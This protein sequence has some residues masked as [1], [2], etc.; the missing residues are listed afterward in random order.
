MARLPLDATSTGYR[1]LA[2]GGVP[3]TSAFAQIRHHLASTLGPEYGH[4]LAEPVDGTGGVDWYS[5]LLGHPTRLVDFQGDERD[6]HARRLSDLVAGLH[7]HAVGLKH[8]KQDYQRHLG[9][10]LE[11]ALQI[12]DEQHVW[13]VGGQPVLTFWGYTAELGEPTKSPIYALLPREVMPAAVP[14]ASEIADARPAA[15]QALSQIEPAQSTTSVRFESP[16]MLALWLLLAAQVIAIGIL[17]L[18]ACSISLPFLPTLDFCRQ[19]LMDAESQT[20][21]LEADRDRLRAEIDRKQRSCLAGDPLGPELDAKGLA[22]CW[23]S[24]AGGLRITSTKDGKEVNRGATAEYCFNEE[25][26]S[27]TVAF[28]G[29]D[30][31][32]CAGDMMIFRSDQELRFEYESL[33]CS[34][35]GPLPGGVWV[36]RSSEDG[37]TL[38][39]G[40][41]ILANG[42][43]EP[44]AGRIIGAQFHRAEAKDK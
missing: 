40:T 16:R 5:D 29:A 18:G 27:G 3:V 12:P 32:S 19:A 22:G 14:A 36:C 1:R 20:A 28:R 9:Q 17:L 41:D 25:G 13:I 33:T 10:L 35:D 37:P 24:N 26:D 42:K 11:W 44:E 8:S 34:A 2:V 39:D 23:S 31:Y 6:R 38:C 4:L 43:P 15:V 21:A 30:G 7:A